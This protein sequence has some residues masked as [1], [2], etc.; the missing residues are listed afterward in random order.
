MEVVASRS[1]GP[2]ETGLTFA[3]V[4]WLVDDN[5]DHVDV[6]RTGAFHR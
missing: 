4:I 5:L 3:V 6:G 1:I 2:L